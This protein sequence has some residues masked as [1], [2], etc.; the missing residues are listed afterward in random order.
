MKITKCPERTAHRDIAGLAA[1]GAIAKVTGTATRNVRYEIALVSMRQALDRSGVSDQAQA[2]F[3]ASGAQ[4]ALYPANPAIRYDGPVI[5]TNEQHAI[6]Q[7]ASRTFV[8]HPIQT[9]GS[10][11]VAAITANF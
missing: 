4:G 9:R 5:A 8:A 11:R 7:V 2:L 1:M 6:Q 3:E 10:D